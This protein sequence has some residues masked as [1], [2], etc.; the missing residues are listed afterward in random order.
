MKNFWKYWFLKTSPWVFVPLKTLLDAK[1]KDIC[2]QNKE[3]SSK[4]CSDLLQDI[5]HPLEQNVTSGIYSKPGG[6]NLYLQKTEELKAKY[7]QEPRKGIQ[8]SLVYLLMMEN[9][10]SFLKKHWRWEWKHMHRHKDE[11]CVSP[12]VFLS[13]NEHGWEMI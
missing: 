8:V 7:Y 4:R 6:H 5:F 9:M 1:Q 10:T 2:T 12:W 3:A 13:L 11:A